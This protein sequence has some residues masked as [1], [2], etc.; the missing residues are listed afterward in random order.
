MLLL[1]VV[2]TLQGVLASVIYS[3]IGLV[4]FV[5]GFYVIRLILPY[6]VHKEIEVDQNTALG[7]VIGSFILGLA[8]II[9]AAISG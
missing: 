7:I 5:A 8:I 4:V 6:D 1:G 3:L 2:V 9:A